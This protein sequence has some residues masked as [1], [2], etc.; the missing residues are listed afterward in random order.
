MQ[1]GAAHSSAAGAVLAQRGS[2]TALMTRS[3]PL[4][5]PTHRAPFMATFMQRGTTPRAQPCILPAQRITGLRGLELETQP[6]V[7]RCSA[8]AASRRKSMLQPMA[9]STSS[10]YREMLSRWSSP[11]MAAIVSTPVASPA[12]GI[13]SLGNPDSPHFPGASFRVGTLPTA[14]VSGKTVVV[15]WA[16][17]RDTV[18]RIFFALSTDGGASWTTPSSGQ[19]LLTAAPPSSFQHFDPQ[20]VVD[21]NGVIGCAFYELG[22]KPTA[23][24]IDVIVARSFD[25]GASFQT[26]TVTDQPWDPKIDAPFADG[27]PSITFIG[28]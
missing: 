28:D 9:Q 3:G 16:D 14:C 5:T 19:R 18:S 20:M 21:P 11:P 1:S 10:S 26:L 15:A 23:L 2:T 7:P 12:T 27:N 13:T 8:A 25:D 24:L 22:P 4:A 17:F 6:P